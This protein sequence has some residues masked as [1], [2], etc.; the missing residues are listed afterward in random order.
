MFRAAMV[1]GVYDKDPHYPDAKR[2]ESLTFTKVL[3]DQLAV[4]DGTAATL[5]QDNKP[6]PGI[7]SG[8]IR[9]TSPG[10]TGRAGGHAGL[11]GLSIP[12]PAG[13]E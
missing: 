8:P 12:A 3:E 11:R 5:C 4:M 7:R 9:T 6:H 2:Y 10:G 13:I 1:D